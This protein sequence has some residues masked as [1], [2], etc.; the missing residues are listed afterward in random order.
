MNQEAAQLPE[1]KKNIK[2]VKLMVI[3][4]IIGTLLAMG[5]IVVGKKSVYPNECTFRPFKLNQ[6]DRG[7]PLSYF[8]VTPSPSDCVSVEEVAA[9]FKV[10]VGNEIKVMHFVADALIWS[11]L[12]G[13]LMLL[14]YRRKVAHKP[15]S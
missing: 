3:S 14:I 13:V 15:I 9:V 4:L 5:S 11:L 2:I 12:P 7:F 10:D 6:I 1:K 8:R